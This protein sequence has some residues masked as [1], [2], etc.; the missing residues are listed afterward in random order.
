LAVWALVFAYRVE[1]QNKKLRRDKYRF[2]W[3]DVEKSAHYLANTCLGK[4]G[5]EAIVTFSGPGAIIANL[6]MIL[7]KQMIPIYTVLDLRHLPRDSP[8]KKG[9]QIFLVGYTEYETHRRRILIP[10]SLLK[11]R[12]FTKIVVL[13]DCMIS[14][15]AI[16]VVI[17]Q[18]LAIGYDR[19]QILVGC[20]VVSKSVLDSDRKP[21]RFWECVAN[22]NYHFP[23]RERF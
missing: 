18:L 10:E 6:A 1:L 8:A 14:G 20:A 5:A 19:K 3:E 11:E 2:S 16:Q 9:S 12:L 17:K 22:E 13:D 7:H 21:D 15:E 4:F 23:W